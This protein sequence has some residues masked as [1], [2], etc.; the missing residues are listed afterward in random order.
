MTYSTRKKTKDNQRFE[1]QP[2]SAKQQLPRP[3]R[4]GETSF[5]TSHEV[6]LQITRTSH[7]YCPMSNNELFNPAWLYV[8]VH[9]R[10]ACIYTHVRVCMSR[11]V[12]AYLH[13]FYL[14]PLNVF[15]IPS[16]ANRRWVH[17]TTRPGI[18][19]VLPR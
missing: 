11:T 16:T 6:K 8:F 19:A 17:L 12:R 18:L 9:I 2:C 1:Y 3:R 7:V 10:G 13:M 5:S 15:I 4:R 14:E